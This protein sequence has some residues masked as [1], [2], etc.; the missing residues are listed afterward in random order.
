MDAGSSLP[1]LFIRS[2]KACVAA[3]CTSAGRRSDA[4]LRRYPGCGDAIHRPERSGLPSAVRGA[5]AVR[6][7]LPSAERGMP[8]VRSFSHCACGAVLN[9]KVARAMAIV[10]V[11]IAFLIVCD[12]GPCDVNRLRSLTAFAREQLIEEQRGHFHQHLGVRLSD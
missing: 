1:K 6:L 11:R 3:G 7:G 10:L 12:A 8:G 4:I 9:A 2:V 5:G